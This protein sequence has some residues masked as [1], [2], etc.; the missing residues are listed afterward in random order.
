MNSWLANRRDTR[1]RVVDTS[2][3]PF[4]GRFFGQVVVFNLAALDTEDQ[5]FRPR[6]QFNIWG[7]TAQSTGLFAVEIKISGFKG[8]RFNRAMVSG[9]TAGTAQ[10]PFFLPEVLTAEPDDDVVISA[11]DLSAAANTVNFLVLGALNG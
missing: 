6:G 8:K 1:R 2:S 3:F 11:V 9:N 7:F 4:L 10:R 5:Q